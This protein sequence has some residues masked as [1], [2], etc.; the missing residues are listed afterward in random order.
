MVHWEKKLKELIWKFHFIVL[1]TEFSN[2]KNPKQEKIA[3]VFNF[4]NQQK[5]ILIES[6]CTGFTVNLSIYTFLL[7]FFS[8]YNLSNSKS[9]NKKSPMPFLKNKIALA[10][11]FD[12]QKNQIMN[13]L[14]PSSQ[15]D[16]SPNFMKKQAKTKQK[17]IKYE[18]M[19]YPSLIFKISEQFR[20]SNSSQ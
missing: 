4:P 18:S 14:S 12:A 10:A 6:Y 7:Q 13:N 8:Y 1:L 16:S 2:L 11:A 3:R 5:K 20:I 15:E 9:D 19:K 17:L